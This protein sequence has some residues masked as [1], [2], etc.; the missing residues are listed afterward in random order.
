LCQI[1][2]VANEQLSILTMTD[3]PE[4]T[5][6]FKQVLEQLEQQGSVLASCA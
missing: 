4:I 1:A 2:V 5:K 3:F 6:K